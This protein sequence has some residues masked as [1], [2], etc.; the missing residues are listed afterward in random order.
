[1]SNEDYASLPIIEHR[2]HGK[3]KW[4]SGDKGYGFITVPGKPDVFVH[5]S[6]IKMEGFKSFAPDDEVVFDI[7]RGEKGLLAVN[8]E[9]EKPYYPND[10][11][12]RWR[13]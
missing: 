3:V 11:T 12:E 10:G 9:K 13:Q 7:A 6:A 1:M 8:V 5:Y 2:V 4:F